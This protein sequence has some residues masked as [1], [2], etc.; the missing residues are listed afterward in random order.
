MIAVRLWGRLGNQLFQY[1]FGQSLS[2]RTGEDL[3]FYILEKDS[4]DE[5]P[6]ICNFVKNIRFLEPEELK[7]H[8]RLYGNNLLVRIERKLISL[9]P[10]INRRILIEKSSRYA[11]INDADHICY[12]GYWQSYRYFSGISDKLKTILRL[13]NNVDLPA[14]L[15]KEISESASV[16]VHFR[17]GDYLSG[18]N[19]SVYEY[20]SPDYYKKAFS[21]ICDKVTDPVFYVFSDDIEYVRGNFNF[22]PE[23]TKFVSH[24]ILPSDCI[25]ITLMRKCKHNIIAN[26]TFS[27]WGAFLGDNKDKIV[28]S[29]ENWYIGKPD[30][31]IHNL[32]PAEW[33]LI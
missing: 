25:D 12:D 18:R 13:N 21:Y 2:E 32:I 3:Y 6:S 4:G 15:A 26:S 14:Q 7:K 33:I 8:Y 27:W 9:F 1:S 28:I 24:N 10:M 31:L 17:R 16:A 20:C 22:W 23:K 5:L 29:P 30:F 19:K 11:E